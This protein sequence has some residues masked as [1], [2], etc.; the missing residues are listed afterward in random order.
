M[1]ERGPQWKRGEK[2]V[3]AAFLLHAWIADDGS[4]RFA[5]LDG[6]GER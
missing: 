6:R 1:H 4:S 2:V 3:M 5:K